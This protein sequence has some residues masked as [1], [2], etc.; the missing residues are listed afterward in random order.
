MTCGIYISVSAEG[1]ESPVLPGAVPWSLALALLRWYIYINVGRGRG[2]TCSAWC[3]PVV[4]SPGTVAVGRSSW[5]ICVNN[6]HTSRNK[7]NKIDKG[8]EVGQRE[9]SKVAR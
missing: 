9:I 7:M 3:C 6:V 5:V 2:V 1:G 8:G 4:S